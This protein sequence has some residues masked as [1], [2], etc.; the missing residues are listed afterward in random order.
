M[1][2]L[3]QSPQKGTVLT[4]PP[5]RVQTVSAAKNSFNIL[6]YERSN[7]ATG[8]TA[9]RPFQVKVPEQQLVYPRSR[10]MA[11]RAPL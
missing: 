3:S 4:T 5:S 11:T 6:C 8:E 10:L 2:T 9:V 1:H 7:A